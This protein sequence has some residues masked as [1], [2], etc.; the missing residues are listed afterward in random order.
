MAL[1]AIKRLTANRISARR[2]RRAIAAL[3]TELG[4]WFEMALAC[5][6]RPETLEKAAEAYRRALALAPGWVE[7]HI[8]LGTTLYQ[9]QRM[10]E[11]K[12][13]FAAAVG[14]EPNNALARFNLGCVLDQL[15]DS[16]GAIE[17]LRR[18]VEL[19][20]HLA[21]AHLNLALVYDQRGEKDLARKHLSLYLHYEPRGPWAEF[22]RSRM[23]PS[24]PPRRSGKLT[25]F[26]RNG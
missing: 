18:A 12:H 10:E 4:E 8:N 22:A 16:Q 24:H 7:A 3:H 6:S 5:D 13:S 15:G 23:G 19:A 14:L 1:E 25:P 26:R 17:H 9:L 11:S 21:D 2:L 20:P